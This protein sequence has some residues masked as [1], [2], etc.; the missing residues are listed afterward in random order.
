MRVQKI[1]RP[2]DVTMTRPD[3]VTYRP[4]VTMMTALWVYRR[5]SLR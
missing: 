3:A 5:R 1:W 4:D 2:N